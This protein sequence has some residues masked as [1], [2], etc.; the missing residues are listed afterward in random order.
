M[1]TSHSIPETLL[2]IAFGYSYFS[3]TKRSNS[4]VQ[5][6]FSSMYYVAIH[7]TNADNL[8]LASIQIPTWTSPLAV[9]IVVTALV[10]KTSFLGHL[11]GVGVGYLCTSS[12]GS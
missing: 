3:Q 2:G 11:C 6:L 1:P 8:S 10:P 9:L 4:I 5:I 7:Q 12:N